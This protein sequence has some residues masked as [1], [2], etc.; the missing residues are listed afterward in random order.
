MQYQ[1]SPLK[2]LYIDTL[3]CR[4]LDAIQENSVEN[5][6]SSDSTVNNTEIDD[7]VKVNTNLK[8]SP[9]GWLERE[10]WKSESFEGIPLQV[11]RQLPELGNNLDEPL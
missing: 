5:N 6:I 2:A 1:L 11:A 8:R 9:V 4:Q 7:N 3:L 10:T